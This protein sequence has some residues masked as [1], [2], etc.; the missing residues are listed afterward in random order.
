L[1]VKDEGVIQDKTKKK[2]WC[3]RGIILTETART[4][5]VIDHIEKRCQLSPERDRE[6]L[7]I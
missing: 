7:P 4:S 1:R 3:I 5:P 6:R 2:N